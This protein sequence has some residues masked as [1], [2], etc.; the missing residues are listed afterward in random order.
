MSEPISNFKDCTFLSTEGDKIIASY[1]GNVLRVSLGTGAKEIELK[2]IQIDNW[3]EKGDLRIKLDEDAI[4]VSKSAKGF[5]V[6]AV[7]YFKM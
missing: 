5:P 1:D 3:Y 4:Y 6:N 7:K 2:G